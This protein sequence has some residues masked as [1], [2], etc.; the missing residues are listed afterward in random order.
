MRTSHKGIFDDK[1][2]SGY[3]VWG[4][5]L[6]AFLIRL[7]PILRAGFP[8]NDG[9]MFYVMANDILLT[10]FRLPLTTSYNFAGIPFFY[11]PLALYLAAFLA[12]FTPLSL[13]DLVRWL[14]L[15][16]AVATVPAFYALGR[17]LLAEKNA[18]LLATLVYALIAP[19][20][21]NLLWGGGLTRAPGTFFSLLT[22][23]QV[24]RLYAGGERRRL[25]L[26]GVCGALTVL[27]H[28]I[29]AWFTVYSAALIFLLRGR[30]WRNLLRSLGVA[31]VVIAL[32][33]PW[34]VT[35][36]ARFGLP[37]LLAAFQSR[38]NL[39]AL[40]SL[41]LLFTFNLTGETF[42][43]VLWI[44]GM[45]GFAFAIL[46]REWLLPAWLALV[47]LL[48]RRT[49]VTLAAI[50]FALLAG[51][52]IWNILIPVGC[53]LAQQVPPLRS[54]LA[55]NLG[56]AGGALLVVYL[57]VSNLLGFSAPVLPA[58]QRAAMAWAAANT[59]AGSRFVV[60]N[61]TDWWQDPV[62]EWFPALAGRASI[63]TVQGSEWLSDE[64]FAAREAAY[65][66]AQACSD[67]AC[68]NAWSHTEHG[69]FN[70]IYLVKSSQ[71]DNPLLEISLSSSPEYTLVFDQ[72]TVAIFA[73][74]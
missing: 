5:C 18:A 11:P 21:A 1:A 15:V 53:H 60:I 73:K 35:L 28:P 26:A 10:G 29:S 50:P 54:R 51:W 67:T 8:I 25:L 39:S 24:A 23:A 49:P 37:P 9:G 72:P 7:L 20:Y 27:S 31:A 63:A 32:S 33:A 12:R 41:F 22:L 36:L 55:K 13:L 34:W 52:A 74:H 30:S 42:L 48:E 14:P 38:G 68:L 6:L 71:P 46:R 43:P 3:T 19:A 17:S 57:L 70:Y 4:I 16:F 69:N 64:N 61:A 44:A 65:K 59:P 56:L 58:E 40:E 2:L 66:A 45:A 62:S 47:F